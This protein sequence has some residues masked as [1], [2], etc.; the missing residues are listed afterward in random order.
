MCM[1]TH[2]IKIKFIYVYISF[3]VTM[4]KVNFQSSSKSLSLAFAIILNLSVHISIEY[5]KSGVHLS[6]WYLRDKILYLRVISRLVA[7][8]F[9]PSIVLASFFVM[10]YFRHIKIIVILL[11]RKC[12]L[13]SSLARLSWLSIGVDYRIIIF[14]QS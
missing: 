5:F 3:W 11:L 4:I 14:I 1:I 7:K 12:K 8:L 13:Q 9:T 2:G 6:G 10:L